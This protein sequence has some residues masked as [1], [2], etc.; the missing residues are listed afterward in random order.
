MALAWNLAQHLHNLGSCWPSFANS[1]YDLELNIISFVAEG[2][3]F[4]TGFKSSPQFLL[5][6]HIFYIEHT[7]CCKLSQGITYRAYNSLSLSLKYRQS[8]RHTNLHCTQN[9]AIVYHII[10]NM[11][12]L[13]LF[14]DAEQ[15]V[16]SIPAHTAP[17]LPIT[18][19]TLMQILKRAE[20][21]GK[22]CI[23]MAM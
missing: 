22:L 16:K 4:R 18:A 20:L 21:A 14:F 8:C 13:L 3:L 10:I 7:D 6:F 19:A 11:K 12:L 1:I 5:L 2:S 15:G 17:H 9:A 23:A